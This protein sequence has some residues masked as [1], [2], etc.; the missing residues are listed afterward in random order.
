MKKYKAKSPAIPFWKKEIPAYWLMII[1]MTAMGI[2]YLALDAHSTSQ[3]STTA[4]KENTNSGIRLS[5]VKYVRET[6]Y[7]FARPLLFANT[8]VED[9]SLSGLKSMLSNYIDSAKK[10]GNIQ[11]ASVYFKKLDS[12]SWFGINASEQYS[13]AS[14][15]KVP[16]M[17]AMLMQ[18]DKQRGY[19]DRKVIYA[20]PEGFTEN[21]Q[22]LTIGKYYTLRDLIKSMVARSDNIAYNICWFNM[23]TANFNK[24]LRD[25]QIKPF[26]IHD[27]NDYTIN[28]TDYSKFFRI[29]YNATYLSKEMSDFALKTLAESDFNNGLVKEINDTIPVA[30]KF[31]Y[32]VTTNEAQLG[33][34]GIFY[35]NRDPYILGVMTKGNNGTYLYPVLSDISTIV[36]T[37]IK[38]Q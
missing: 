38:T 37:Q 28:V 13:T 26:D 24:L 11:S 17:I 21:V 9:Q 33:E 4:V 7:S 35:Y 22:P 6:G 32:R 25:V 29:L 3:V 12:P 14:L 36:Y 10:A 8:E 5:S 15:F 30:R 1:F 16:V 34:F 27:T 18:A 23:D 31:G 19:L 2:T 20:A